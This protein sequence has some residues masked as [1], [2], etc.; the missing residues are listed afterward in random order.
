MKIWCLYYYKIFYNIMYL[1]RICI[2]NI[3]ISVTYILRG[4]NTK[5]SKIKVFKI[6]KEY[7]DFDGGIGNKI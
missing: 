7:S 5:I 3:S 1:T 4:I 2:K 6:K